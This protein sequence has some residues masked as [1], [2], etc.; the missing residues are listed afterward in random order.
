MYKDY[1][2]E[3]NVYFSKIWEFITEI[4]DSFVDYTEASVNSD[5]VLSPRSYLRENY[6]DLSDYINELDDLYREYKAKFDAIRNQ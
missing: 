4:L 3:N 5:T 6:A 1:D 2:F